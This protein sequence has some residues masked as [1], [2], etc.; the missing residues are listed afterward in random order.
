[1]DFWDLTKLL[2]RRWYLA[3]PGIVVTALGGVW[4]LVG[5][6]PNY[7]ATAYVQLAPPITHATQP[8]E[9]S[10]DQ[11]NPWIGLGLYNLANAAIL[12]V[13]QQSVVE[14]LKGSGYSDSFTATLTS[15]SPL[16]TFEVTGDTE[17][18][19]TSTANLL[20]DRFTDSVKDLQVTTYGVS[21]A[22][23]VTT[24]RIDLGTNIKESDS[25]VKRALVAVVGVGLLLTIAFTVG[26]DSFIR[27]RSRRLAG[28]APGLPPVP[29]V[30]PPAGGGYAETR[31]PFQRYDNPVGSS[32]D[33]PVRP[34]GY[35]T[36][37]R[38]DTAGTSVAT[39]APG[40]A[41]LIGPSITLTVP[42][43]F[44]LDEPSGVDFGDADY[45]TG[46]AAAEPAT[47]QVVSIGPP[48]STVVLPLTHRS[49]RKRDDDEGSKP[50]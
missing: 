1:V 50:R 24:R 4:T 16:V 28:A 15:T 49:T 26:V 13:Q 23:L 10:L 33:R 48:D 6:S 32:L 25:R 39:T 7:I 38:T 45:S 31:P 18:Q 30:V 37:A 47:S 34:S 22:D 20:V 8:G 19:A 42:P 9:Q 44:R 41:D 2:A 5:V 11:R 14:A 43:D 29:P 36:R 27:R 46:F 3:L 40:P 21:S 35:P 12:T 17:A